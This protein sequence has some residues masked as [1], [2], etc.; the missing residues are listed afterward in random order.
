MVLMDLT[1]S[2]GNGS[3]QYPLFCVSE[4]VIL[5]KGDNDQEMSQTQ[6]FDPA[7][8]YCFGGFAS[9]GGMCVAQVIPD[10]F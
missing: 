10:S 6:N 5:S 1:M 4:K 8:P 9:A 2:D 3:S 7:V